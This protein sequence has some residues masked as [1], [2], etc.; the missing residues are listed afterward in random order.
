M[1]KI[2]LSNGLS[3]LEFSRMRRLLC[4]V[5]YHLEW[6]TFQ[7]D[8]FVCFLITASL[9][10]FSNPTLH[11]QVRVASV[12]GL[13]LFYTEECGGKQFPG[14]WGHTLAIPLAF[15][16]R[17]SRCLQQLQ[18][19]HPHRTTFKSKKKVLLRC[20]SLTGRK[21]LSRSPQQTFLYLSLASM[22]HV[23]MPELQGISWHPWMDRYSS[24]LGLL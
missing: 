24:L 14:L 7:W 13:F 8:S 23:P 4:L 22:G 9:S 3:H 12:W 19:S 15:P 18:A 6:R 5:S 16:Q 11:I 2:Q 20:L 17:I 1:P 21:V 10:V